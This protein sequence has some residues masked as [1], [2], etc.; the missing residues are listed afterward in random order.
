ME[1]E[2]FDRLF[3]LSVDELNKERSDAWDRWTWDTGSAAD[4]QIVED[5]DTMLEARNRLGLLGSDSGS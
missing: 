4:K 5:V 3:K 2:V 1:R